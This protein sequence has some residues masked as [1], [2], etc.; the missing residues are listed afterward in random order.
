MKHDTDIT[1]LLAAGF[2]QR[3]GYPLFFELALGEW[4]ISAMVQPGLVRL[5]ARVPHEFATINASGI[6]FKDALAELSALMKQGVS[7]RQDALTA[8]EELRHET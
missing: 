1:A 6:N 4:E 8:I 2:E 3:A 7:V 5:T